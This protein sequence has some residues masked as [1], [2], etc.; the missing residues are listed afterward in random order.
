MQIF[1]RL[2][3]IKELDED[4]LPVAGGV[5]IGEEG[6]RPPLAGSPVEHVGLAGPRGHV[7]VATRS[8]ERLKLTR[9][10][11]RYRMQRLNISTDMG[12]DDDTVLPLGKENSR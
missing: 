3:E 5:K 2:E 7:H 10:S 8:A 1:G 6:L 4:H 11:L 12:I 9:H